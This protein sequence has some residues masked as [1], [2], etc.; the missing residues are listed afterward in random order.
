MKVRAGKKSEQPAKNDDTSFAPGITLFRV[1]HGEAKQRY[2]KQASQESLAKLSEQT[3]DVKVFPRPAAR[4]LYI[5]QTHTCTVFR[6]SAK[7]ILSVAVEENVVQALSGHGNLAFFKMA[8]SHNQAIPNVGSQNRPPILEKGSYVLWSI[9]I[10]RCIDGKKE[11]ETL[12]ATMTDTRTMLELLQAP[13]EGYRDAIVIPAILA[14]DF[15][16]KVSNTIANPKGDVKAITTRSSVAYD[17]TTIPPTPSPL[18]KEVERVTK[19]TKD[20]KLSLPDLTPTRMSLELATRS[21]AYPAGIAED[22]FVYVGKFTFLADFIVV[23]YDFDPRVPLILG[24]PFLRTT[25]ALVDVHG[26]ELILRDDDEKLIFH[27]DSTSKHPHK[28][29]NDTTPLSDSSHSPTPFE[30]CDSLLKEFADELALLDP[31]SSGNKDDNFDFEADLKETEYLLNQDP[32]TESNI[33]TIGLILETPTNLLSINHLYREMTMMTMMIF[34]T[35]SLIIMNGKSFCM[36]HDNDSTLLEESSESSRIAFLSSSP[37]RN[38]D[39]V[40]NPG[41]LI[42]GRTQIFN[43]ESKDKDYKVNT[44][45]EALLILEERNFLSISSNK[46][47]LFLLG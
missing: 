27:Y 7:I 28:H 47:L 14:E 38:E 2:P 37:F 44:S 21:Y 23:N 12:V 33:E 46:E 25:R 26:E 1:S 34:L 41:I 10:M 15:E 17:G 24:R 45:S 32:S 43:D 20:K 13:T 31:F 39:K 6:H 11:Y 4:L 8:S 35:L 16:L 3:K 36:L 19:V 40:F 9:K 42:L 18:P 29:G 5:E 30:T 22:V